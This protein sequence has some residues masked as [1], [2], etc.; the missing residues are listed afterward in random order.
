MLERERED[1]KNEQAP[2]YLVACRGLA[3]V[4]V[5]SVEGKFN[6]ADLQ[7]FAKRVS[8]SGN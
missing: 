3:E 2:S 4:F 5:R 7:W 1:E 6:A 8:A